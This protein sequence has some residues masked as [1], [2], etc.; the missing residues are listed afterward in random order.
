[1]A[2]YLT[3][4]LQ[5]LE[6]VEGLVYLHSRG[7]VHGDIKGVSDGIS[8]LIIC[9]PLMRQNNILVSDKGT[10]I[11]ADFGLSR[12]LEADPMLSNQ[13][14]TSTSGLKG[15]INWIAPELLGHEAD[16]SPKA[17]PESDVWSMGCVILVGAFSQSVATDQN[18]L[19]LPLHDG[20]N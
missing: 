8:H 2:Q 5:L 11:L 12:L 4:V 18:K 14:Y 16:S 13:N 7:V 6:A 15:T 9:E 1:M 17:S 19:M 20:R 3:V 10:A